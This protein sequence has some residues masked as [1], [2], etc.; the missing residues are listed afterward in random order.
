MLGLIVFIYIGSVLWSMCFI[1]WMVD[2]NIDC[3]VTIVACMFPILNTVFAI[4]RTYCSFK[5]GNFFLK[6]LFAN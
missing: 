2:H 1:G 4:Y 6:D 5:N 3:G